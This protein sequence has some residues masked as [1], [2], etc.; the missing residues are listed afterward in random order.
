MNRIMRLPKYLLLPCGILGIASKS[1]ANR[2]SDTQ[3]DPSILSGASG[4]D[5]SALA[6]LVFLMFI[7]SFIVAWIFE[8]Q[9]YTPIKEVVAYLAICIVL[10]FLWMGMN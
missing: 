7:G 9:S 10:G 6:V 8:R 4:S 3:I 1:Y 5:D 2:Y